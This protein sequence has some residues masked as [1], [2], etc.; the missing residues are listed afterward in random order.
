MPALAGDSV[1]VRSP[2]HGHADRCPPIVIQE[3]D[4][5]PGATPT[6]SVE[7]LPASLVA[8]GG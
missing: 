5:V 1:P 4:D 7:R 6:L 2:F 8:K 3:E